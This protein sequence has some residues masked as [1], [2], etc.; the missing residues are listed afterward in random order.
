MQKVTGLNIEYLP[1]SAL[2]PYEKNARVH[3]ER[4]IKAIMASIEEVGFS[5]P[6]GVWGDNVIVEGHGRLIAAERL[7]LETVPV[8]RLDHMTDEQRRAYA[9][10][11]NRTA[12]MSDWNFTLRDD[13]LLSLDDIDLSAFEFDVES[14]AAPE[15]PHKTLADS[16]LVP[17]F[18]V[19]RG[20]RQAWLDRK[21]LWKS[22]GIQSELGRG[23]TCFHY[24]IYHDGNRREAQKRTDKWQIT[25]RV[26]ST[27]HYVK[28]YIYGSPLPVIQCSILLRAGVC[29]A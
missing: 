5:D 7:G 28:S 22:L 25:A 9:I 24:H 13:E 21:N 16:F 1:V 8:I 17:P 4:D 11:H 19:L 2:K 26:F 6:I 3:G 10:F 29:A 18:S 27:Q 12:E 14:L 23:G 15:E 20:D